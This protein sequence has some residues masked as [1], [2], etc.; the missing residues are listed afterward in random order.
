MFR[1]C[2]N[3]VSLDEYKNMINQ[4]VLFLQ[5]KN[6]DIKDLIK[7]EMDDKIEKLEFEKAAKLKK[8]LDDIERINLKQKVAN[9]NENSTDIFGYVH[10]LNELYVQVFKIRDYKV[11]LHDNVILN[12]IAK[13][14]IA[15]QVEYIISNYYLSNEDIPKKV[16]V[17]LEDKSIELL[18]QFF[19]E[20][21]IN[22]NVMCPKK[23]D[24]AKLIDM[25]ENNIHINIEDRKNNVLADLSE[26]LSLTYEI[27]SIES[28]DISN[29]RNEYIVGCMIR[30]E[31]KK[32]NKK[33]YRKFKIKSTTTQ[34]DPKSMYEVITRRLKHSEDWPLPDA[35]FIDGG[36]N[37]VN[38]VKKALKEAGENN[39]LVYGMIKNDKH[40][41]KGLIDKDGNEIDFS[42]NKNILNFL[43]FLQDEVHRFTITYH[44]K[45]RDSIK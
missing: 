38:V 11:V 45:L 28:F 10:H 7:K 18:N 5:G 39:V 14:E 21:K 23:G 20:K 26:V 42:N 29:L 16:Y 3:D 9:L 30:F 35:F 24:K 36:K 31:D 27:N 43:T 41:T 44:R 4:I 37:Q 19:K 13:E 25:V 32:L 6:S 8:R 33:M 22:I 17:K 1:P 12:D 40:R 15:E 2:I 34:D